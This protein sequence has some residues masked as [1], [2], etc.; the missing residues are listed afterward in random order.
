M[1]NNQKNLGGF[2]L[3]EALFFLLVAAILIGGAYYVGSNHSKKSA[4]TNSGTSSATPT[5]SGNSTFKNSEFGFQFSYPSSWGSATLTS[6]PG[7]HGQGGTVA[8]SSNST[9]YVG[10]ATTDYERTGIGGGCLVI[11]SPNHF[12]PFVAEKDANHFIDVKVDEP[13]LSVMYGANTLSG[14]SENG[15]PAVMIARHK[16]TNDKK[17]ES[18]NLN[19]Y[20]DNQFKDAT[21]IAKYET[22]PTQFFPQSDQDTF[23]K[24]ARSISSL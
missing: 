11:V 4:S 10:F 2:A 16:V 23:L 8:F 7:V 17:V 21:D 9:Y 19:Y 22:D 1:K 15:C 13:D 5:S 18:V 14:S 24:V 6:G 20:R 12:E 3:F